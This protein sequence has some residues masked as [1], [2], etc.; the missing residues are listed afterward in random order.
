MRDHARARLI[1]TLCFGLALVG[2]WLTP[3]DG[4]AQADPSDE[5]FVVDQA[6]NSI[7][8]Y[9]RTANGNVAPVRALSGPATGLAL[10]GGVF[11]DSLN[12][13]LFITNQGNNSITVYARTA[14]G[15]TRA[16][17]RAVADRGPNFFG[18]TG[19]AVTTE[20][21]ADADGVGD[22][23][24]NCQLVANADQRDSN[25]DGFGNVCDPDLDDDCIV[26][27]VDLGLMKGVFFGADPDADLDGNGSVN[28]VDLGLLKG[29]FFLP[30]GPTGVPNACAGSARQRG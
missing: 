1:P 24:D 21:D 4:Q 13:E 11:A 6:S 16:Q 30:P 23:A 27:F 17:G 15:N 28:F 3:A 9:T 5:I 14:S 20:A 25:A 2:P 22:A 7:T 8:V 18:L 29:L 12:D 19:I 26:N 10:P